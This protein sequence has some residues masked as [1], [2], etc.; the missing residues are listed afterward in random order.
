[1]ADLTTRE[2]CKRALGIPSAVTLHD[3]F[4]DIL[5]D[6]ADQ[7][8]LAFT[9]Q[10]ALTSSTVV[11]EGYDITN[12]STTEV[13][14]RNFPVISVSAVKVGGSTLAATSWYVDSNTGVIRL[15]DSAGFFTS[16][17]QEVK[18]SYTYGF[19][20]IPA[21]LSHAATLVVVSHFN[22]SRHAGMSSEGVGS[23][24]YT[25]DSHAFPRGAASILSRYRRIFPRDSQP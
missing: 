12:D 4:L 16:G 1:M 24:R 21:D 2:K 22:R 3:D 15:Q 7:E 18:V 6:V 25:M 8:V 17:T 20:T 5:L 10:A 9:G 11:D 23:Y 19:S 14:L 13:V